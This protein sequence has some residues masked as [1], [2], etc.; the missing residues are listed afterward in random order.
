MKIV[1][2]KSIED[3]AIQL[4][5]AA[6]LNKRTTFP[7]TLSDLYLT[8]SDNSRKYVFRNL[9]PFN[10]GILH[11][12]YDYVYKFEIKN[13]NGLT[14]IDGKIL[15]GTIGTIFKIVACVGFCSY[16]ISTRNTLF[17]IVMLIG[18]S[19]FIKTDIN[20][21]K[22]FKKKIADYFKDNKN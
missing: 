16:S 21:Y 14:V 18:L 19:I 1:I 10:G 22:G 8:Y 3:I 6:A 4:N 12:L 7:Y 13:E 5:S 2:D 11:W 9:L 20:S 17:L 15:P